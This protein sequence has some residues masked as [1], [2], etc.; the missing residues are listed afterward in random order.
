M[1]V[2]GYDTVD[3]LVLEVAL[4]YTDTTGAIGVIPANSVITERVVIRTTPWDAITLFAVGKSGDTYWL[5]ANHQHNL[6]G[7]GAGAELI[8]G[9][10]EYVS[11]DTPLIATWNQGAATQGAG[12]LQIR[13]RTLGS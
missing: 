9:G 5:V 12:K 2:T 8:S 3:D 4:A 11:T 6:D 1:T 10:A 13:Y 7:T